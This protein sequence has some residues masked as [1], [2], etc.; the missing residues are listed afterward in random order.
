MPSTEFDAVFAMMRQAPAPPTDVRAARAAFDEMLGGAPL[1]DGVEVTPITAAGRDAEWIVPTGAPADR[2]VLYLHGG[3][4]RIGS[5]HGY[6]PILSQF[7]ATIGL[8]LFAVDYR[9]APE[10]PFPAGLD[11]AVAAYEWL[12]AEGIDSARV[13]LMGDSAGGGLAA[14]CALAIAARGLPRPAAVVGLSPFADCTLSGDS[15][16]RNAATDPLWDLAAARVAVADYLAGAAADDPLA[17]PV[18]GDYRDLPPLLVHAS[19]SEALADDAVLLAAAVHRSGGTVTC[20]LW[21]G[22]SHVWHA[23]APG[24]P[25]AREAMAEVAAFL[26]SHLA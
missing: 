6:R 2:V 14:A 26:T 22:L 13:A 20:G 10:H 8:R 1:A 19:A 5:L 18:F 25:E 3:G 17:S 15:Y 11:D 23:M 4:Y 7:A 16:R 21:P 12:L 9:L 24:V